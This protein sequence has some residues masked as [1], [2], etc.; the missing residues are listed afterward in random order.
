MKKISLGKLSLKNILSAQRAKDK[1]KIEITPYRDWKI[2]GGAFFGLLAI[3]FAAHAY[4]FV[5][6][7]D[8]SLF[9]SKEEE[10]PIGFKK[11][12]VVSTVEYY[13]ERAAAFEA[14]KA[15]KPSIVDPAV[16][17]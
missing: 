14:R 12:R 1:F 16:A 9:A 8:D 5:R 2:V 4:L 10:A 13:R 3:L 6:L 7:Q 11:E 15:Q 17:R